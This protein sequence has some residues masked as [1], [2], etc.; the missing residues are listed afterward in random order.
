MCLVWQGIYCYQNKDC[1]ADDETLLEICCQYYNHWVSELERI[2]Y[3]FEVSHTWERCYLLITRCRLENKASSLSLSPCIYMWCQ[4]LWQPLG[5]IT[6]YSNR[7]WKSSLIWCVKSYNTWIFLLLIS[8]SSVMKSNCSSIPISPS[9]KLPFGSHCVF[10][11]TTVD[12][13]LP[14]LLSSCD[15]TKLYIALYYSLFENPLKLKSDQMIHLG[16]KPW[17]ICH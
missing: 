4:E 12:R 16:Q 5:D 17:R 7:F 1:R 3:F 6:E 14:D 11:I 8:L 9:S 15:V 10:S 2:A 13:V